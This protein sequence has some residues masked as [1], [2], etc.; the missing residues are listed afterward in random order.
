MFSDQSSGRRCYRMAA[1]VISVLAVAG[2]AMVGGALP[3][4]AA[5]AAPPRG[6]AAA[7]LTPTGQ[8]EALVAKMT[9]SQKIMELHGTVNAQHQRYVP[10]IP[11]LGIPPLVIT[12][13]PAGA[14]PGDDPVQQPATALPAPISLAASF[15]PSLAYQY[16]QLMGKEAADL[17]NNLLEGP[18]V[19]IVRVYQGGRTFESLSEDP[20]LTSG[21]GTAEIEGIQSQPAMIDE[22]K[23]FDAYEQETN[24]NTPQDDNI[25][26]DRVLHEIYDPPFEQAVTQG[27]SQSVMC[28]YAT[29][30]GEYSCQ[31]GYLLSTTLD[32]RWGFA[33]FVQSDF[34]ATHSTVPSAQAG[35]D[36][37][38]QT[39]DY[40]A[41]PLQQAVEDG[42]VP[43]ATVNQM[44]VLRYAAMIRA[45]LFSHPVS[46]R[47]I[48][49]QADGSFS[50]SAAEQGMVLLKNSGSALP[51]SASSL[52]S[53]AVI[54]PYA[55]AA[56]TGG[57]GSSHV[58]PLYTVSPVQGIENAAGPGVSVS[59]N[60]GSDLASAAA[61]AKAADVAVVMV[62]DTES[63]GADQSSLELS[64][65]Q[66]Q[67]VEAVAAAN[68]RTIV[69]VKSGNP[70]LMPWLS[71]VPAVL[72]AWYPGEEDGNAVAAIL[73]GQAD[74][75]GKLPVTFPETESQ[76]PTSSPSQ[77]PGVNGEIDYS[78]GLDVGYRWYDATNATPM[79]P[80]GYGLSY[81]SFSYSHL[82][83]SRGT[84]SNPASGPG[85]A[86][87][88]CNGQNGKLVTV[89]ATVTNTGKVAGAD[90]AQLYLSDPASAGEPPRQLKGYQ[91]VSLK[92]GQSA[93]VHFTLTG[94]DLSYWD[95]AA[96]GWV[97]PDGAFG[98][99]VGD[100][101]ALA[102]LPLRGGFT[103]SRSVGARYAA[104]TAPG[105]VNPGSV[106]TATVRLVNDG[107]YAMHQVRARLSV[108]AGWQATL[109]RAVP[110]TL[111]PGQSATATF[112][113]TVPESAQYS[114]ATLTGQ[115]AS[116]PGSG[117]A[118]PSGAP[119]QQSSLTEAST[120]VT[121]RPGIMVTTQPA[122]LTAGNQ[123]TAKLAVASN[124]PYPVTL[125][126]AADPPAGVTVTPARGTVTVPPGGTTVTL[127]AA[128]SPTTVPAGYPVPLTFSFAN[129]GHSYAAPNAELPVDVSYSSLS[130]A[131]DNVGVT[132]DSDT[133]PGD[134]A[135]DG[136]SYSQEQLTAAELAPG[137]TV[138]LG[139]VSLT[140][141][142]VP[143]GQPDNAVASG[144]TVLVSGSGTTL[145]VLG[146]GDF[147][148]ATGT[149]TVLYSDGTTQSFTLAFND[150]YDNS[151]LAGTSVVATTPDWNGSSS[152]HAIS[153]YG[154]T[155]PI[156]AGKQVVAVTLP[157]VSGGAGDNVNAM[158][159]FALGIG[160]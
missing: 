35:L 11:S 4:S 45:G 144:Q 33:G 109:A 143:A 47:T 137:A 115:F 105:T 112:K 30:N 14:G 136:T 1:P 60:D 29:I 77:F 36:L 54:G 127:T 19:N 156:Q 157:D 92:P 27:H 117:G 49:A 38:M 69:V 116:Q 32:Q 135:G 18:D 65:N 55:G 113:V 21:I 85:A 148:S 71:Q 82:T 91:R 7:P 89:S 48:P 75:S 131:Y 5:S 141:P 121:V 2:L 96:N 111:A 42:Q 9:L 120:A 95:D 63:E 130:A 98:V 142:D 149:G 37:E 106:A 114:S 52:H 88:D 155:I 80:F 53:I 132:S 67:L 50:R 83:I 158:H 28:S 8:A 17:G 3:S 123:V 20:Y 40:Y 159:V 25:V 133:A 146:A 129:G 22:V 124:L 108:P 70:V 145:A 139:G 93:T 72:E 51:L 79:F 12:N 68:P 46:T 86:S 84:V 154:A 59:Y 78:E 16:G 24:R 81:T 153:V 140:W 34:G 66:D 118:G 13:G 43:I 58:D 23:H 56:M 74:P 99:Y 150:W 160:G 134:F 61:A 110:A 122:L 126:Y 15:D 62:G 76:T 31:N 125:S 64:G 101:S 100:S 41:A 104:V 73:F 10:G 107:D 44:L 119:G 102:S 26:S 152:A 128:A 39:G 6:Q 97:V 138:S 57:G 151:A 147:G 87:C 103:V 94:H 90:V